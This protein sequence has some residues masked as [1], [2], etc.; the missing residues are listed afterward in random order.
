[1]KDETNLTITNTQ[2]VSCGVGKPLD[3]LRHQGLRAKLESECAARNKRWQESFIS[4][5]RNLFQLS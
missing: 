3:D 1:M 5:L 4:T 2:I